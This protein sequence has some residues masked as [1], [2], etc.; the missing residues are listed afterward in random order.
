MDSQQFYDEFM[1]NVHARAEIDSD[2]TESAFLHEATERL[3]DAEQVS[4]L[5]PVHFTGAGHHRRRLAVSAYDMD[6]S[7]DSIALAVIHFQD[8]S[9]VATM[10]ETE[11]KREF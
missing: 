7:D 2:F 4:D 10:S 1:N 3:V 8:G 9:H 11:A 5:T 6:E